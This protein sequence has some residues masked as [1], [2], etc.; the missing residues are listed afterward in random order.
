MKILNHV[1]R[2]LVGLVFV[3]SGLAKLFPIEPFEIIFVD[4]GVSN[5]LLAPF[6]ARFIIAFEITLGLCIVFDL[7]LKN[8]VY[9][10]ALGSLGVFMVYLIFLLITKGNDVDCGCFGSYL[11]LTPV[12]SLIKNVVLVLMLLVIKRRHHQHGI[13]NWLIIP[14][15]AIGFTSTF[16]LNRVG[17]QN[18]Q[19]MELNESIDYSGF[20]PLYQ[21]GEKVDFTQGKV[22][23]AF[24]SYGCTHCESAAHKLHYL[25]TKYE[26]DNLYVVLASKKEENIQ[27]FLDATKIDYPM[28]WFDDE[29]FFNYSGGKLPAFVYLEDGIL[30]KKWTGEFFKVEELEELV[31]D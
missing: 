5:W 27:V 20:P 11:A 2:I 7:W 18:V 12:E 30:K 3:V 31:K 25:Q 21:T 9:K 22:V 28:I 15:L 14:F 1:I 23:I 6:I 26:I 16:L 19:A 4:L 8:I 10:I 24:L 29:I 17:L 13:I